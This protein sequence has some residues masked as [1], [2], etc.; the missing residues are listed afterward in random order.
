MGTISIGK[1]GLYAAPVGY[2]VTTSD[3]EIV[4]ANNARTSVTLVNDSD[5]DV[6]LAIEGETAVL[7]QGIRL[8]SGGGSAQF[9]GEGGLPLTKGAIRGIHGGT[10]NK[11]MGVQET[12]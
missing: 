1:K 9:G 8:N 7:N 4:A 11:V 6:Y 10:G 2:N 12:T 3:S 5:T